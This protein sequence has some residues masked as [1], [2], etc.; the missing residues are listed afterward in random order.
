MNHQV[1]RKGPSALDRR[2]LVVAGVV[3]LGE[4][5]AIMDSTIVNVALDRLTTDFQSSFTTIQWVVTAYT[6]ALAA[7]I[8]VSGWA[9][10]R[11][12]TKRIYLASVA[13]FTFG[14]VLCAFAWNPASLIAFRVLQGLGGG[15]VLPMVTTIVTKVAGPH[16]RGR[17]MGILGVP[18]LAAPL[19]GPI[20][21]GWLVDSVSWRAVFLVNL[22][23]GVLAIVL[24]QLVLER[25]RPQPAFRPDWLGMAL[26]SPGL[27]LVIFGF[28][29]SPEH[30]FGVLTLVPIL[31]GAVLIGA[32][33]F[34]SWGD[35][36][37]LIDIKTFVHSRAGAAAITLLL[38]AAATLGGM[39]LMPLYFQVVRGA[40]A[41][42][43]GLLLAPQGAGAMATMPLAGWIVDRR[44]PYWLTAAAVP[45]LVIGMVPF[46]LVTDSTPY[47]VLCA[48]NVIIGAGLG[49]TFM[50]TMTSA[51]QSVPERAIGRTST[52]MNVIEQSGASTG[53][54]IASVLLAGAVSG[55]L[56]GLSAG[57]AIEGVEKIAAVRRAAISGPLAEAFASTFTWT[58]IALGVLLIPAL[59]LAGAGRGGWRSPR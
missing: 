16:R 52:A 26:L 1:R 35:P 40:S 42:E 51:L 6:L 44:G 36:D 12:G 27:A 10:D 53:T 32:F 17:V 59:A 29:E 25:D 39:L 19:F 14:S 49:L 11:F 3:L 34:H 24:A 22:P 28:A 54:A 15:L 18:V 8:P 45:L 38:L 50:P 4:V 43:A 37:P 56:P 13:A 46:A 47:A 5:M 58:L 33:F 9:G 55:V 31:A 48:G 2:T 41:L 23:I 20:L 57:E 30:G 7:V 21:G